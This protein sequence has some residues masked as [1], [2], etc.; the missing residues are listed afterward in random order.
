MFENRVPQA[1]AQLI[2]K[3]LDWF[4]SEEKLWLYGDEFGLPVNFKRFAE[5]E[6]EETGG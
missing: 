4:E 5:G 3:N 6:V 1:L 2:L